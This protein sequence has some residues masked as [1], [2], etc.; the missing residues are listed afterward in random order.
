M[1]SAFGSSDIIYKAVSIFCIGIVVLH[2]HFHHDPVLCSFKIQDI[3]IK[4]RGALVQILDEFPDPPFVM[5]DHLF[6]LFFSQIS[7][8]DLQTFSKKSDLPEAMF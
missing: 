7:C 3:L 1:G 2:G 5:E 4:R 6:R 8:N